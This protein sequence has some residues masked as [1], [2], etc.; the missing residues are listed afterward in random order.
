MGTGETSRGAILIHERFEKF[1]LL[2]QVHDRFNT[3]G[4]ADVNPDYPDLKGKWTAIHFIENGAPTHHLAEHPEMREVAAWFQCN[5]D[6]MMFY[7]AAPGTNIHPHRDLSGNL[8]LGRLRFHIPIVTHPDVEFFIGKPLRRVRLNKG[9]LWALD[10]SYTHAVRNPTDVMRCHLV[11]EV[12]VNDFLRALLPPRDARFYLHCADFFVRAGLTR[13][14]NML[15][16]PRLI[17]HSSRQAA[18]LALSF[19]GLGKVRRHHHSRAP[20]E[21]G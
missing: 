16:N 15:K 8:P 4:W 20:E 6:F 13:A 9:E 5:I 19:A 2:E 11:V 14:A 7:R 1:H 17:A 18:G 10:T 12:H 3:A 21:R